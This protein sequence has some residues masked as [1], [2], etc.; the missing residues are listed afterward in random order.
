MDIGDEGGM[1]IFGHIS[2]L[3]SIKHGSVLIPG[4]FSLVASHSFSFC[5]LLWEMVLKNSGKE[6][7]ITPAQCVTVHSG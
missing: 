6:H 1:D 7:D 2:S 3:L 4:F 5:L